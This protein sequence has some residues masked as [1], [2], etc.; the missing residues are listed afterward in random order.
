MEVL[1]E[2]ITEALFELLLL[3]FGLAVSGVTG[4]FKARSQKAIKEGHQL[5]LDM[6]QKIAAEAVKYA[7]QKFAQLDGAG[8]FHKAIDKAQAVIGEQ[9]FVVSDS[10]IEMFIESAVKVMKD[11]NKFLTPQS[12]L[13][14]M[15]DESTFRDLG[16]PIGKANTTVGV[17]KYH[18]YDHNVE[19][20]P[21]GYTAK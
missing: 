13:I 17:G 16:Q 21:K 19:G 3:G 10:Q 11:E 8:R 18:T 15:N 6:I 2:I 9:G 1:T 12:G 4:F 7:E 5:E 14:D 20:A